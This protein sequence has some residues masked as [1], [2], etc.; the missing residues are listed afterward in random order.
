MSSLLGGFAGVGGSIGRASVDLVLN[1][2]TYQAEL[3]AT[4]A[5]T[6]SATGGMQKGFAG[7]QQ[8]V[9]SS[10]S[11]AQVAM[12]GFGAVA[13]IA[14]G[15]AVGA[16]Q[17][18]SAE[19]RTLQRVTGDGAEATSKLAAAGNLLNLDVSKLNTGFGIL[20]K[21]IVNGSANLDKYG[22]KTRD[23]QGNILPFTEILSNMSDKFAELPSQQEKSAFAMN[24]FG[25]SGK[26]LIPILA[27][28]SEGLQ[29]LYDKAEAAGLVMSQETLDASKELGIAQRDLG[30]AVKGA[31]V[32]LGTSFLPVLT[33]VTDALTAFVE[34]VQ[35]I[36]GPILAIT[37]GLAALTAAII[38]A[39]KVWVA[40]RATMSANMTLLAGTV[41]LIAALGAAF[42]I[43]QGQIQDAKISLT[44]LG[45]KLHTT[46][47]FAGFLK[48]KMDLAGLAFER[49][50]LAGFVAS[51]DG[52]SDNL[53]GL[54]EKLTPTI[55]KLDKLGISTQA[56]TEISAANANTMIEQ[57]LAVDGSAASI[58][59]L[60]GRIESSIAFIEGQAEAFAKGTIDLE[61]FQFLMEQQGLTTEEAMGIASAAVDQYGKSL[62]DAGKV[63]LNFAGFTAAALKEWA[64]TVRDTFLTLESSTKETFNVTQKALDKAFTQMLANALRFK[65]DMA[66]LLALKPGTFGL[67]RHDMADFEN[68]MTQQGPGFIDAFVRA[69]RA[70][71][72]EYVNDWART[73]EVTKSRIINGL[74]QQ[75]TIKVHVDDS[76]VYNAEAAIAGLQARIAQGLIR[77]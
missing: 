55:E 47:G 21:N 25:R 39:N 2:G 32:Q 76:E 37:T 12:V 31:S 29:E 9:R 38:V 72:Q 46:A 67:S 48:D 64:G 70:K 14:I 20:N 66:A 62:D 26:E 1:A 77:D 43:V 50:S 7:F 16:T 24:A 10:F 11:G 45:E 69:S 73:V 4:E 19:V 13:A 15:K 51:L 58:D 75:V 36:P 53:D 22:V 3:A 71:Q 59:I 63:T 27:R 35:L 30:D 33:V 61:S 40:L 5:K 34:L 44:E 28:G 65:A 8:Q 49:T 41:P 17:E 57:G 56:F 52:V 23:A 60:S 68:F 42:V 18:W 6:A 54:V 74:P